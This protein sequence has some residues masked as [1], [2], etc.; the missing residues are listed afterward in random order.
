MGRRGGERDVGGCAVEE[1]LRLMTELL[2][3]GMEEVYVQL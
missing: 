2:I 1:M 3:W